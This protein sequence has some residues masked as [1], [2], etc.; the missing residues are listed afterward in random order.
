[1]IKQVLLG[2]PRV[3]E[4]IAKQ[5]LFGQVLSQRFWE[6]RPAYYGSDDED[7]DE[8]VSFEVSERPGML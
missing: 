5:L 2:N 4:L 3:E 1:M 7:E 6:P 8:D